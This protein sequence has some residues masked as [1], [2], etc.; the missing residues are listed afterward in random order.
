MALDRK[1]VLR[2]KHRLV[3][4]TLL[5]MTV[6]ILLMLA[7]S[8]GYVTSIED[9]ADKLISQ[10]QYTTQL[11]SLPEEEIPLRFPFAEEP[12]YQM[13]FVSTDPHSAE[14]VAVFEAHDSEEVAA[15]YQALET[16]LAQQKEALPEEADL[17]D[18]AII[19]YFDT[20]VALCV[21]DDTEAA[22]AVFTTYGGS[23]APLIEAPAA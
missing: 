23:I 12:V 8:E 7:F 11:Q 20:Y 21:T 15:I 19:W 10:V 18:R 1:S 6:V 3:S 4:G 22:K 14:E 2:N 5:I 9:I 17:L 13:A 16:H